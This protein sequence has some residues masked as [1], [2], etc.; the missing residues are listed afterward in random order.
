MMLSLPLQIYSATHLR[1][2]LT[3]LPD[4]PGIF[5]SIRACDLDLPSLAIDRCL[6]TSGM[7]VVRGISSML[8]DMEIYYRRVYLDGRPSELFMMKGAEEC[9]LY[10]S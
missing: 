7:D 1:E 6:Q 10:Q 5:D 4:V 3:F 9:I 8:V 2:H